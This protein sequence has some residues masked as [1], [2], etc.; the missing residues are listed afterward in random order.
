M[1]DIPD[2]GMI[3]TIQVRIDEGGRRVGEEEVKLAII[4]IRRISH[5]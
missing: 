4:S 5:L 2:S 3:H 1:H